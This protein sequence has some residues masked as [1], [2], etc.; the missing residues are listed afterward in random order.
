MPP[1]ISSSFWRDDLFPLAPECDTGSVCLRSPARLPL[2]SGW[3]RP[4]TGPATRLSPCSPCRSLDRKASAG[5]CSPPKA[6]PGTRCASGTNGAERNTSRLSN[7]AWASRI[8]NS[9]PTTTCALPSTP[10][11]HTGSSNA[12]CG[13]GRTLRP[14]KSQMKSRCSSSPNE[15]WSRAGCCPRISTRPD[16]RGRH[17]V[18]RGLHLHASHRLEPSRL[19]KISRLTFKS[20]G[21]YGT[22]ICLRTHQWGVERAEPAA[23]WPRSVRPQH[24]ADRAVPRFRPLRRL[25]A[26][27]FSGSAVRRHLWRP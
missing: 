6:S 16:L 23:L 26:P 27:V 18:P 22:T 14:P 21:R 11:L 20:T 25:G 2:A 8:G 19:G 10:S 24:A 3:R 17:G 12:W 9:T 13:I 1:G 7:P 15:A 4:A 5:C